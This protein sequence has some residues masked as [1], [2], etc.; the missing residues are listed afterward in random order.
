MLRFFFILFYYYWVKENCLLYRG[1]C[2]VE[3]H[4]NIEV[5]WGV[6]FVN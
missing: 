1:L 2:F 3:V 6:D 4:Y 5:P